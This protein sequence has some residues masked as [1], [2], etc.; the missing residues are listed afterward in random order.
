MQL[1]QLT[2]KSKDG[3]NQ[4]ARRGSVRNTVS[5][6]V[7]GRYVGCIGRSVELALDLISLI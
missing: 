7:G 5:R 1:L 3:W 6:K 2:R 4:S